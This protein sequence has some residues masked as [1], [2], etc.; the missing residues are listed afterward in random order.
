MGKIGYLGIDVSKGY[1]DFITL[2][3]NK[4]VIEKAFRLYDVTEGH[5]QLEKIIDGLFDKG[6]QEVYCGVESTGGYEN[7]WVNYLQQLGRSKPVMVA[8]INPKGVKSL[9][10][11]GLTR[12]ITDSV[13]AHNIALYLIDFHHKLHF[14][15]PSQSS[16]AYSDGR[17]HDSYI[18]M[19]KKQNNQLGNQLEKILYQ[20]ASPL[21]CYCRHGF[22][23]W[24][25]Q[26]LEK[27]PSVQLIR[28]AGVK[29]L[30]AIKGISDEKAAAVLRKI[31]TLPSTTTSH[32]SS[33]IQSTVKQILHLTTEKATQKAA[34][35]SRFKNDAGA[36]LLQSIKGVGE[37]SAVEIL[38]EIEDINRFD[39]A[40]KLTAYF[41]THPMYKQSGD[42][43]WGNHMSKKGRAEIRGVLYMC[44]LT[45]IR[46]DALFK[47]KYAQA[48]ANGKNHFSAMGV[49]INKML[50][51]VY[52]VL[53]TKTAY[54]IET[55]YKNQQNALAQQKQ[56]EQKQVE[57]K[58]EKQTMLERYN[59]AEQSDLPISKR[60]QKRRGKVL[61]FK[62][63]NI[64]D[65]LP[66][67]QT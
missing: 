59:T 48:R 46:K 50:R 21:M 20:E 55:D 2:Q 32:I 10:E 37:Q 29:K 13:S 61:S 26:L 42:G 25:L 33:I 66:L 6:F 30:S 27:Y 63:K 19:L 28:K 49:V 3:A 15:Q 52:G 56:K 67:E 54:N 9:G 43:T 45:A 51:I 23:T 39:S 57:E 47:A 17:K 8:R 24:L 64:Q 14:L 12:T 62:L 7:N 1:A 53:K 35:I 22:P 11:A 60:H 44:C 18:R 16:K 40:K 31:D 38:I 58:K 36:I 41:G 4:E 5:R 65:H 34:L